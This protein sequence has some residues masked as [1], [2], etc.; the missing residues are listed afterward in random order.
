MTGMVTVLLLARAE[1][2]RVDAARLRGLLGGLPAQWIQ[3]PRSA[4]WFEGGRMVEGDEERRRAFHEDAL[5]D[6][7]L[8]TQG[9]L[10]ERLKGE[11]GFTA[12]V[13]FA[14][15]AGEGKP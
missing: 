4:V 6:P 10:Q 5:G 8:A 2:W 12:A 15:V 7:V 14:W 1:P 11:V 13:S 9:L 3:D